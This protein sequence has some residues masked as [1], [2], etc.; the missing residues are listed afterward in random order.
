MVI[1]VPK[2]AELA[3]RTFNKRLGIVGGV[4]ILGTSGIVHPFS[5]DAFV[6]SIERH[7]GVVKALGHKRVVINSGGKSERFLKGHFAELS[8][9]LF[10]QY[11]N[12]IGETL[13]ICNRLDIS[14][15]T[16]GVMIGKAVKLAEGYLDTHS[17][18]GVMN[19]DFIVRTAQ[20]VGY[21]Q[22]LIDK[23][24]G[25][26]TAR[27]LWDI[28]PKGDMEL[29]ERL[30]QQCYSHTRGLLPNGEL[31]ILFIDDNGNLL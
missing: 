18:N 20:E 29:F 17:K 27:E 5:K 9:E 14:E 30:K 6:E 11:G 19:L 13:K 21:S 8:S 12:L 28:A 7:I 23:I 2:G 26:T 3:K 16:L 1:S 4:S 24:R 10:V 31:T 25:I 22:H 15:V